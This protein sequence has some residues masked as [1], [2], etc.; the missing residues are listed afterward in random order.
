VVHPE[1]DLLLGVVLVPCL[2]DVISYV[3]P[4]IQG[5]CKVAANRRAYGKDECKMKV[6][7][8]CFSPIFN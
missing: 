7:M 4:G 1:E 6:E 5:D 3:F 8:P 2:E